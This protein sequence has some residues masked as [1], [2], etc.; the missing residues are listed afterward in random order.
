MKDQAKRFGNKGDA[1]EIMAHPWWADI[2]WKKLERKEITTPFKPN[3]GGEKWLQ[4]FDE[5]FVKEG[6]FICNKRK[7]GILFIF[8]FIF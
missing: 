7:E 1:A 2:D 3:L 6:K 4:N 8:Y 5:E